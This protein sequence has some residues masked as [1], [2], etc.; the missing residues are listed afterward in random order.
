MMTTIQLT[1]LKLASRGSNNIIYI[2]CITGYLCSL[3]FLQFKNLDSFNYCEL[4]F[5]VL[6]MET[7]TGT[8]MYTYTS[9]NSELLGLRGYLQTLFVR[10]FFTEFAE[11]S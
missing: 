10:Y 6:T 8:H 2:Y 9:P 7:V 1:L 3:K 5:C 11:I 4:N